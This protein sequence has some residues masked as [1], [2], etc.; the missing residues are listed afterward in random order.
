[1]KVRELMT[2]KPVCISSVSF[3]RD[4]AIKMRE[5]DTGVLPVIDEQNQNKVLGLI[6][7][8]D[9][10]VRGVAAGK[11][12]TATRVSEVMTPNP[13][14]IAP[15]TDASEAAD[16]MANRQVRRLCVIDGE[17]LVGMVS[18][19]DLAVKAPEVAEHAL[20]GV[21]HGAKAERK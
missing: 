2:E 9:I 20:A 12:P 13:T 7:D 11:D 21:S 19:G 18:L 14:C 3:L 10:A 4:A 15:D 6:T 5:A 16:L 8:R 17:K 1:M